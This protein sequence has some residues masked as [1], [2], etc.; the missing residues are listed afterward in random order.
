MKW[1]RLGCALKTSSEFKESGIMK[2][3]KFKGRI[4]KCEIESLVNPFKD[5]EPNDKWREDLKK[6]FKHL[7]F[8]LEQMYSLAANSTKCNA[9]GRRYTA[10]NM[11]NVLQQYRRDKTY[12][13]LGK[14]TIYDHL[15]LLIDYFTKPETTN[16]VAESPVVAQP[17]KES[18]AEMGN[19]LAQE[20]AEREAGL[21]CKN[22]SVSTLEAEPTPCVK[23][24]P[25]KVNIHIY[26]TGRKHKRR[27]DYGRNDIFR[28]CGNY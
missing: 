2:E 15:D 5:K 17:H 13:E 26:L 8:S 11:A 14:Q 21:L 10:T 9:Y 23:V 4:Q 16:V 20:A 27:R 6:L 7:H 28:Q 22:N 18:W 19:R 25:T 12:T 1:S 24:K 3:S